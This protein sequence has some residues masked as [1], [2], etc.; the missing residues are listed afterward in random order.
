MESTVLL[1]IQITLLSTKK[2]PANDHYIE[3]SKEYIRRKYEDLKLFLH[4][5]A[6]T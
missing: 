2:Y 4:K 6:Y 3:L 5:M 1:S